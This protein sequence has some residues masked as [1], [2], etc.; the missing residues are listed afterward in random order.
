MVILEGLITN[1]IGKIG[2]MAAGKAWASMPRN[3]KVMKLFKAVGLKPGKPEPDFD[4]VY[5]HALVEYGV[6]QPKK[7]ILDFFKHEDI[8]KAFRNSFDNN[9][10]AIL[11]NEAATLIKWNMIGDDLRDEDIDPRLEFARFTLVFNEMVDR[12]RTPAEVRREH[13]LD[14]ILQ[15]IKESD[16]NIIRAKQIEMIQ[17]GR[18]EQLKTWFQTLGYSFGGHDICTDEYCEW[19]IRIST[20]RGFDSILVRFI[21]NQ[22]EPEDIKRVEAA[23]KQHQ[24]EEGWLIAAHRTSR[25][26]KELAENSDKI[27]HPSYQAKSSLH[28]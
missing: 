8:R 28:F 13:K 7:S 24:T 23:V 5:V 6:E 1:I 20:R 22:A 14:E 25:S 27:W 12:T 21:E 9:D 16:L 17:G 15:V 10:L 11:H 3:H 18:P 4:S 26:A 2:E 19:I